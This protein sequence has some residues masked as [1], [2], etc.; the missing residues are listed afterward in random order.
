MLSFSCKS[1]I[2]VCCSALVWRHKEE[3]EVTGAPF[4]RAPERNIST[5]HHY[6]LQPGDQLLG[7]GF[8]LLL[9]LVRRHRRVRGAPCWLWDCQD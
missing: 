5:V 6:L 2:L 8:A 7:L 1:C 4:S 9:G 3:K